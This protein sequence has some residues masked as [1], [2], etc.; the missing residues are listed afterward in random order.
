MSEAGRTVSD[1]LVSE[2][3]LLQAFAD[4]GVTVVETTEGMR[5]G[6][7]AWYSHTHRIVALRPKLLQR[8][9]IAGVGLQGHGQ[10][11][12][13]KKIKLFGNRQRQVAK[14]KHAAR[15]DSQRQA[16]GCSRRQGSPHPGRSQS[17]QN[18]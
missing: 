17:A 14:S 11:L 10:S 8:Q 9:R 1:M 18:P 16:L 2:S 6:R 5:D 13:G 7:V 15:A 4:E 12:G 3:G